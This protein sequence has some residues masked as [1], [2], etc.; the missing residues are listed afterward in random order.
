MSKKMSHVDEKLKKMGKKVKSDE[1]HDD[2]TYMKKKKKK[3]NEKKEKM[4]SRV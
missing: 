4:I 1:K 2:E 3:K